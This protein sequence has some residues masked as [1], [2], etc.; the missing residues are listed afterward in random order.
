MNKKLELTDQ[1]YEIV[2]KMGKDKASNKSVRSL[3]EKLTYET[4]S[5][6]M[7]NEHA[8]MITEKV[9]EHYKQYEEFSRMTDRFRVEQTR[10]NESLEIYCKGMETTLN[11]HTDKIKALENTTKRIEN[12]MLKKFKS[13]DKMFENNDAKYQH[14]RDAEILL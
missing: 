6:K 2:K 4:A 1:T 3:E 12:E 14:K 13:I 8:T 11:K 10:V 9:A 7:F 5:L